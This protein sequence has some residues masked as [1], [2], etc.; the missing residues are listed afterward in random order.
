ML[1]VLPLHLQGRWEYTRLS[2]GPFRFRRICGRTDAGWR[3]TGAGEVEAL[4]TIAEPY[5][6]VVRFA[7]ATGLR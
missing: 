3:R 2:L 6:F 4:A 7:L 5:G 1:V